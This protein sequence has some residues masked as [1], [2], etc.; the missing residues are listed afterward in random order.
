VRLLYLDASALVRLALAEAETAPLVGFLAAEESSGITLAIAE[1]EV[2]RAVRR[3]G[4]SAVDAPS[5]LRYVTLLEIDD[6]IRAAAG[7]IAPEGLGT[8]DALHLAAALS[9]RADLDA[10]VTYEDGLADAC[11]AAGLAVAAPA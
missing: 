11:R 3:M 9:L 10:V 2:L 8:L 7:S 1:T 4:G 5:A 6:D